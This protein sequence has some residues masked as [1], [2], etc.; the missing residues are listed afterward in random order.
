MYDYWLEYEIHSQPI[1][2]SPKKQEDREHIFWPPNHQKRITIE[3]LYEFIT[4]R[5]PNHCYIKCN[6]LFNL[7]AK[8]N[9]WILL[10]LSHCSCILC[11]SIWAKTQKLIRCFGHSQFSPTQS[12]VSVSLSSLWLYL[13]SFSFSVNICWK[14][15]YRLHFCMSASL[16][17]NTYFGLSFTNT[18][19]WN[20]TI[21][22]SI[23]YN[24]YYYYRPNIHNIS[25]PIQN[26]YSFIFV[27]CTKKIQ[28]SKPLNDSFGIFHFELF[29]VRILKYVCSMK[30]KNI[31]HL[32]LMVNW[33]TIEDFTVF[34]L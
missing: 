34:V 1:Y 13:H 25:K 17:S 22:V 32:H 5:I 7:I 10:T 24:Y 9:I 30:M 28:D 16:V 11:I 23:D 29:R 33:S 20:I 4:T 31:T 27:S 26:N 6:F 15:F 19:H 21:T 3:L 2:Y 12:T 8:L 14:R 18:K